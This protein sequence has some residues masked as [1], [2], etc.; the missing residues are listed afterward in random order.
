MGYVGYQPADLRPHLYADADHAGCPETQRSTTGVLHSIKGRHTSF[1]IAVVSKRQKCVS[2]STHEAEIAALD[3]ALRTVG[4]PSL[5][6]WERL[7]GQGAHL[8]VREDSDVCIRIIRSGKNQTM[9]ALSR[10]HGVSVVWIHER[11]LAKDFEITPTPSAEMA[12]DT[13]KKSF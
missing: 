10:T 4:L 13:F 3:H 2:K 12:T 1:P 6:V 9:R 7:L 11:H 8:V 5:Q